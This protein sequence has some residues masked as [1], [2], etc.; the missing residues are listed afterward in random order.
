MPVSLSEYK[1]VVGA[2]NIRF[3]HIKQHNIFKNGFSQRKVKQ[4]IAKEIFTVFTNFFNILIK[5]K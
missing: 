5:F 4:N 1:G 2:F 3:I